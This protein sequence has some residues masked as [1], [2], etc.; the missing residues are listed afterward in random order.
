MASMHGRGRRRELAQ[1]V[2]DRRRRDDEARRL[3][4]EVPK[5]ARLSLTV[6]EQSGAGVDAGSR[7]VRRFVVEQA[8]AR[9]E[10]PCG[11]GGCDGGG[12]DATSAILRELRAGVQ[13]LEGSVTCDR[14]GCVLR[15][16]GD[17]AYRAEP[18]TIPPGG[19]PAQLEKG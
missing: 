14:C 13:H 5:L 3:L 8:A 6:E 10:L 9:F 18:A 2:V 19:S 12:H 7:H 1:H 16:V 4:D 15:D 11:A 17:A